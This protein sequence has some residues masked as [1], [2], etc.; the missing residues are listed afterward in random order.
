[1]PKRYQSLRSKKELA[2]SLSKLKIKAYFVF[3]KLHAQ[4][5]NQ[6]LKILTAFFASSAQTTNGTTS[7]AQTPT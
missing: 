1:L 7:S 3:N 2:D 6:Q 4:V 5:Q